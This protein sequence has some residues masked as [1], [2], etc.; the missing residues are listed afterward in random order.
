MKKGNIAYP[1]V[2]FS[3][4]L[5]A[6]PGCGP[7]LLAGGATGAALVHDRRTAGTVVEDQSIEFK[8]K[9]AIASDEELKEKSHLNVTSYNNVVLVTGEAPTE[10]LKARALRLVE[11][12]EKVKRVYDEIEIAAPSALLARGNDTV[13]TSKVKTRLLAAK[14][15]DGT[16]V[17]VVTERGIVYLMGLVSGEE[18]DIATDVTRKTRGVQKVVRVFQYVE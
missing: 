1:L 11:D 17:K 10:E 15:L 6:L 18:A 12:V 7:A 16:R 8:A 14:G 5:A 9:S 2:L 13:L 3:V 4:L